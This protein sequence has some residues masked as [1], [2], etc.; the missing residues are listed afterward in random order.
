MGNTIATTSL[1]GDR[2]D[3]YDYTDYGVPIR[4]P[5]ALDGRWIENMADI[6][7]GVTSVT[8]IDAAGSRLAPNSL[9]GS[10]RVARRDPSSLIPVFATGWVI[11]QFGTTLKIR[12]PGH[13]VADAWDDS[14]SGDG[15]AEARGSAAIY[16]L[17]QGFLS[18]V[19]DAASNGTWMQPGPWQGT[20]CTYV[21]VN[22][23]PFDL[24]MATPSPTASYQ[25]WVTLDDGTT[26][27]SARIIEVTDLDAGHG[28]KTLVV[29]A[30]HAAPRC[31]SAYA[32][33]GKWYWIGE[34]TVS[35][36]ACQSGEWDAAA[37][38]DSSGNFTEFT[39]PSEAYV[40]D[41][42]V[43]WLLQPDINVAVYLPI[44]SISGHSLTV[45]GSY[46]SLA[47]YER[48]RALPVYAPPG[49]ERTGP[50][51]S[52]FEAGTL[53]RFTS[54]SSSRNLFGGYRYESPLAQGVRDD[55]WM[56]VQGRQSGKNFTGLHYTL[57]RHYDPH[58][59]RFT[60]TRPA[61]APFFNLYSYCGGNPASGYDPDGL[62]FM[63][64]Y[65][66]MWRKIITGKNR[67]GTK[68][69][70]ADIGESAWAGNPVTGLLPEAVNPFGFYNDIV[71]SDSVGEW[72]WKRT[73]KAPG[74]GVVCLK[75]SSSST[76]WP[77]HGKS[78]RSKG[79]A[80]ASGTSCCNAR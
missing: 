69:T 35:L 16:D 77:T 17:R 61:A 42:Q 73:K 76:R 64:E 40:S 15:A 10:V 13:R 19:M 66:G 68:A 34:Q 4:S 57:H 23:A 78:G 31:Q 48:R 27:I 11:S 20:P 58:L 5:V 26:G 32:A 50:F 21:T 80:A 36:D 71:K 37:D 72:A 25:R 44:T 14:A 45:S 22:T 33:P 59:M 24:W 47:P 6:G 55:L 46:G 70:W 79:S 60:S 7:D 63:S 62:F 12:D 28:Y 53:S 3:E 39:L 29:E 1:W 49:V 67:D 75:A 30:S 51:Y 41:F 9:L 54:A 74:I 65:V 56:A 8:L 43:G 18:G 38:Q 52:G 2:L